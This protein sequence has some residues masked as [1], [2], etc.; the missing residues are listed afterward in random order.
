MA[1][2][3]AAS[4][5]ETRSRPT[6]W[7]LGLFTLGYNLAHHNSL[8]GAAAGP[9][10]TRLADWIDLLTPFVVALPLLGFLWLQ[11][12][13]PYCWLL[14]A[15]GTVL[16][17]EGH[18]IHL[19][20]NSIGNATSGGV[21]PQAEVTH[22]WD[23]VVGHYLWYLGLAIVVSACALAVRGRPL[24]LPRLALL[25]GGALC[26]LT[27]A[28]NGLEGGTALFS[29]ACAVAALALAD[30]RRAGLSYALLAATA[31]AIAVLVGYGIAHG[32]FPQP[33]S[34]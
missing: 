16:Y 25:L 32:G 11:R 1:F 18:G 7:A 6:A 19:S 28:T 8:V 22:L 3:D 15:V 31:V 34:L 9:R 21:G 5:V 20:A 29:L 27:W 30:R 24:G 2:T 12:P 14:A 13:R 23:E 26:G 10:G 4:A 33:S 17:V